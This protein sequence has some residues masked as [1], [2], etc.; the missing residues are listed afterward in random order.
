VSEQPAGTTSLTRVHDALLASHDRL[1][2]VLGSV[3]DVT[4]PS[5]DD[6]WTIADVASHLGSG[7]EIFTLILDAGVAGDPA[8]GIEEFRGIWDRWDAKPPQDQVE[9]AVRSDTAFLDGLAGLGEE[10]R[11]AWRADLFGGTQ[12]LAGVV[13]M[14]LSEHAMHTWDILV[15]LDPTATLE[16]DATAH[17]L[18][19]LDPLVDRT[20]KPT[21]EPVTVVVQTSAPERRLVLEVD[22]QGASLTPADAARSAA[23]AGA[24]LE[25]PAEAFVRLVYGRL[26]PEHTP[27]SVRAEGVDLDVLRAVFPG[28]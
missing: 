21:E 5:Y 17:I 1:V 10:E 24:R 7:A 6:G 11:A 22:G 2:S 16:A 9:D 28:L 23:G 4:R 20:A 12:D 25:L 15:A 18:G 8:P 19:H 3:D 13:G 14:R 26:D 27:E